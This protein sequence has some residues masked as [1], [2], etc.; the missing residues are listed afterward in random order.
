MEKSVVECTVNDPSV[1]TPRKNLFSSTIITLHVISVGKTMAMCRK[2]YL[3][4]R[5]KVFF[6]TSETA[7]RE[8]FVSRL[9]VHG[10][11]LTHIK[12][13]CRNIQCRK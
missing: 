1:Q 6:Y 3:S 8:T 12:Y 5:I 2:E 11:K 9:Y 13:I 10:C 7:S 4:Q